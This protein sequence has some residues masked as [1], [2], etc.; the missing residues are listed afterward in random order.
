MFEMPTIAFK[1]KLFKGFEEEYKRRHDNI[2]PELK[3]LLD[4]AGISDYYIFL[5]EETSILFAV[6]K[7]TD[8]KNLDA[9]PHYEVMKRWWA[10][11]KDIMETNED[12]SPV[13]VPLT[14][15]FHLKKTESKIY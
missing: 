12:D 11:M 8:R 5:D 4:D 15:V 2:W 14:K 3:E 1:M 9:L 13:S 7:I 6:M 10:Q